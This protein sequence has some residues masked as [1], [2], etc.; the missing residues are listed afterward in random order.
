MCAAGTLR[1]NGS[2]TRHS[3][4]GFNALVAG[5]WLVLNWA[6]NKGC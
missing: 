4:S 3:S 2:A 6:D 1:V 5:L